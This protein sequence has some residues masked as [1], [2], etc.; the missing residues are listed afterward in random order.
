M[1]FGPKLIN[2]KLENLE[3]KKEYSNIFPTRSNRAASSTFLS[4]RHDPDLLSTPLTL[5]RLKSPSFCNRTSDFLKKP[6]NSPKSHNRHNFPQCSP[7]IH[8]LNTK[9]RELISPFNISLP[10]AKSH[11]AYPLLSN[12]SLFPSL[13]LST[14]PKKQKPKRKNN[15][16]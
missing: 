2:F 8:S 3:I 1:L 13:Q 14:N 16:F 10:N 9:S 4:K 15:L 6:N 5:K 7:I 11:L 12:I